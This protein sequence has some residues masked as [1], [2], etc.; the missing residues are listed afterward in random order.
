MAVVATTT[1]VLAAVATERA[2]AEEFLQE[3]YD[4]LRGV[5][6]GTTDAVY[7][8]DRQGRYLMI[9]AA[10]AGFLG[11]T[12]EEVIGQ[13][14]TQMFTLETAHTIM[15]GDRRIMATGETQTYEDVGSAAGATP[16]LSFHQ[17]T[18]PRCA[19]DYPRRNWHLPRH[20]R[21]QAGGDSFAR[22]AK[23]SSVSREMQQGL[24]PKAP[25]SLAGF[26]IAGALSSR[27]GNW[28]GL[29]RLYPHV[30]RATGHRRRRC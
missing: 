4:L 13:D 8:K 15:E 16:H 17:G 21:T 10:G 1:L 5:I 26:A 14:D 3:S 25:P 6:E 19:G 22:A 24:F 18:L 12:V 9:N 7:V 27:S 29:L 2:R 20:H 23:E 11:R 30:Q 28:R